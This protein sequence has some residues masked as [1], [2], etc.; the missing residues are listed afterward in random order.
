MKLHPYLLLCILINTIG[1]GVYIYAMS[2]ING[3][4]KND[5]VI[6]CVLGWIV[7]LGIIVYVVAPLTLNKRKAREWFETKHLFMT[8]LLFS[9]HIICIISLSLYL[10]NFI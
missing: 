9:I 8:L 4:S 6:A 2:H 3:I 5:A 7:Y 1:C 10:I